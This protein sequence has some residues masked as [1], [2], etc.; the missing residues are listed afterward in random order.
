MAGQ[1]AE[2]EQR[3]EHKAQI[4]KQMFSL[5]IEEWHSFRISLKLCENITQTV[6]KITL[7]RV[8]FTYSELLKKL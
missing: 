2:E 5:R 8:F 6:D 1:R 3:D 4:K 7:F